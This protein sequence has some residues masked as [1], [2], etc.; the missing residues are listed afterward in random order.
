MVRLDL[1]LFLHWLVA[2]PLKVWCIFESNFCFWYEIPKSFKSSDFLILSFF[3]FNTVSSHNKHIFVRP[4]EAC[5]L[6]EG[7]VFIITISCFLLRN[8]EFSTRSILFDS[9]YLFFELNFCFWVK[10]FNACLKVLFLFQTFWVLFD[11]FNFS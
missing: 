4:N 2:G 8:F 6:W 1:F 7:T 3:I 10:N 9:K 11:T 5:L